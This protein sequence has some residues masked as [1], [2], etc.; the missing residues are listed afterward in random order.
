MSLLDRATDR[1]VRRPDRPARRS[2]AAALLVPVLLLLTGAAAV[3]PLAAPD[4]APAAAPAEGF[5][6]ERALAALPDIAAEPHPSGSAAQERVRDRLL[7]RLRAAGTSP[8]VITR[9]AART[10]AGETAVGRVSDIYATVPGSDP[11]GTVLLVAHY[12]SVPTGPGAADNGANVAAALEVLRALQSGPR[13]RND[14]GL[15]L[16]DGEEYG[17]LGAQAFVDAGLASDPRRIVA[18]NLEARGTS[19]PAVLFQALG[20]GLTPAVREAGAYT[21][22]LAD[23]V[24]GLLPNDTDLTA[25]SEAG[26][27]G[28]NLAYF[29][30][31]PHYHTPHD[32]IERVSA[33]STQD[34]G[35][36]A[37]A[38]A[39]QLAGADLSATG[40]RSTYFSVA[41]TVLSYP[42]QLVLPLAGTA[43]LGWTALLLF[44]R[45]RG[46]SARGALRAAAALPAALLAA[47]LVGAAGWWVLSLLRPDLVLTAGNAY[48]PGRYLLAEAL[49]LAAALLGWYRW[50]RRRVAPLDLAMGVLPWFWLLGLVCAVL[51][52]GASYLFTW[53]ALIGTA[54][55]ALAVRL[56][57]RQ[58]PWRTAAAGAAAV[59][60]VALTL[61]LLLLLLPALGLSLT[62]VPLVLAA[63]PATLTLTQLDPLLTRLA[64]LPSRR[65]LTA[66][67]SALAL[68]AAG[69]FGAVTALDGYSADRP[70]AVSL[71]YLLDSDTGK[72]VWVSSGGP[73]QPVVGPLLTD[74]RL[75]PG[76]GVPMLRDLDFQAGPAPLSAIE[77]PRTE[78]PTTTEQDGVRTVRTR[79][80]LPA[81]THRFVLYANTTRHTVLDATLDGAPAAGGTNLPSSAGD[82]RWT[83]S[84]AAPP[85]DGVDL[86]LRYRGDGPLSLQIVALQAGLPNTPTTPTLPADLS[87]AAW[88]SVAGQTLVVRTLA[89]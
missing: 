62:A 48:H 82:W 3:V 50:L 24:F 64:P 16:T 72:A 69:T 15:L 71:G 27:R 6:A 58:S 89:L 51:L 9:V 66:A 32:S 56:T 86:T 23:E 35:D 53:P 34:T 42:E 13:P 73:D 57:G 39:R 31:A 26:V 70:R 12:D 74:G 52:P 4:P 45:R 76:D 88:P 7:E 61:P 20:D 8:Q 37:L 44:G 33:A 63:L 22:S 2:R 21:T 19:G 46:L 18:V 55:A 49:L 78:Q 68:A 85:A 87:W 75:V 28:L 81:G 43:T 38:A 30:G 14:I 84:Y 54:A 25:L 60:A 80:H 83:T 77:P 67:T 79:V 59:P 40:G 65:F 47:A 10:E 11:T 17:L 1:P 29:E 36:A 41:G 5:S